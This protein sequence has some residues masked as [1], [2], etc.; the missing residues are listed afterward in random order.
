M[1]AKGTE[2]KTKVFEALLNA[3]PESFYYN[4]GKEVRI[5]LTEGGEICQIKV[6]CTCAKIP[7]EPD[8]EPATPAADKK[9]FPD[10]V[11]K[12]HPVTKEPE[13]YKATEEEKQHI[14]DLMKAFGL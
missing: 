5:N 14:S 7:V 4:D 8:G 6:A 13:T 1:A 10:P 9:A 2:S 12:E 3:F 11:N